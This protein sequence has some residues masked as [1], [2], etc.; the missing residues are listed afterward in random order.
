M[1]KHFRPAKDFRK[2]GMTVEIRPYLPKGNDGDAAAKREYDARAFECA[3][4]DL[5]DLMFKEGVTKELR[6]REY[7][8]S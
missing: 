4:H 3:I 1:G 2:K 6:S 5:K 8:Q 7:F